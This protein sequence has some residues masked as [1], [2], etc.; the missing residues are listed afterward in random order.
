M[1][2]VKLY[3]TTLRDGAAREGISFSVDDKLKITRKLADLGVHYIEGG[4]PGSNPK[5][6]EFFKRAKDMDLAPATLV[7]F[8]STRRQKTSVEADAN[9]AALVHA[10]TKV[11]T[12]VG[13]TWDLHVHRVLE[14]SL[15]ENLLMISD[16]I[17]YLKLQGLEVFFDAE[18]FF[19]GFGRTEIMR[20]KPWGR[21]Q[22]PA[23]IALSFVTPMGDRSLRR[24]P[25]SVLQFGIVWPY[26]S[27]F[28]P[29]TIQNLQ[30]P[31]PSR[32]SPREQSR[33]KA[34]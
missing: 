7:A 6:V 31:T 9:V 33:F 22:M 30:S 27:A 3:D 34:R 11:V 23:W 24:L 19:D 17:R 18:H 15:S 16:T 12:V 1:G 10:G 8:G 29:I 25:K 2:P 5:D 21:L 20:L 26:P 14:T 4:W 13:K 32:Q 28:M